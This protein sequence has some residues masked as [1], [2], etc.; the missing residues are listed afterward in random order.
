MKQ[1]LFT[2]T[3]AVTIVLT[4]GASQVLAQ[5]APE[6]VPVTVTG[7]NYGLLVTLAKDQVDGADKTC[8]A[9]NA[10]KVTEAKDADGEVIEELAGKT[11]HYL[12][13]KASMALLMG[14]ENRDKTV[15]V[16]GSFFKDAAVLAVSSFEVTED[17]DEFGEFDELPIQSMSNQQIL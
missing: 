9:L 1:F 7:V 6:A 5:D 15:T 14:K 13:N 11:L 4:L 2:A 3:L 16:K 10:L 17:D 12:P 8:A